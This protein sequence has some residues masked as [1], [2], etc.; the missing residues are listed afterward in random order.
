MHSILMSSTWGHGRAGS[1]GPAGTE[2]SQGASRGGRQ[3]RAVVWL[4]VEAGFC[5]Q[6]TRVGSGAVWMLGIYQG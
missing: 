2:L 6:L 3:N 1:A 4:P 5:G